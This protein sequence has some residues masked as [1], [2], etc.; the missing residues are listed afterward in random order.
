MDQSIISLVAQ[1]VNHSRY[2]S[3]DLLSMLKYILS[4]HRYVVISGDFESGKQAKFRTDI[5]AQNPYPHQLV[6]TLNSKDE[7]EEEKEEEE[8]LN[9][10]LD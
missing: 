6:Y 2:S 9:N 7:K 5:F 10:L 8:V 1:R 4:K 3:Q